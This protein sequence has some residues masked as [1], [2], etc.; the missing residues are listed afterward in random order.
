MDVQE[1]NGRVFDWSPSTHREQNV[2]HRMAAFDCFVVGS[3]RTSIKRSMPL[4]LDQRREGAC[5]GFGCAHCLAS[6]LNAQ[7]DVTASLAQQIYYQARREDEWA[8]EDYDGSSVNGAMHAARTLGRIKS[9]RWA[10]TPSEL[11]HGLSYHGSAEAGS[12]WLSNMFD[13]G[14]DGFLDVSGEEVGG[15]AYCVSGY[16]AAPHRAPGAVDY[17]IDN[18][19][20]PSWGVSGGAWIMDHLAHQLWFKNWGEIA[21]PIK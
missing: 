8:G 4:D 7:L 15:H 20:G 1:V 5:T 9:W 14:D 6:S 17:W 21:F 11:Q 19:W 10:L 18:S 3:R 2:E 13:V 12:S 16:R